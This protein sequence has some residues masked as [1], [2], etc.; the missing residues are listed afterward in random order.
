VVEDAGSALPAVVEAIK[1]AGAEVESAR[2]H[3]LSF[4]EIFAILVAR[5]DEEAARAAAKG[6]DAEVAA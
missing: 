4:D 2:E 6:D 1:S 3:R 5:H